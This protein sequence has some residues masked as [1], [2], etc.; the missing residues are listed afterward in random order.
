VPVTAPDDLVPSVARALANVP[1]TADRRTIQAWRF[2][3]CWTFRQTIPFALVKQPQWYIGEPAYI[4]LDALAPGRDANL[5]HICAVM[6][7]RAA[8]HPPPPARSADMAVAEAKA[9]NARI[10]AYRA[11]AA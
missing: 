2:M 5:D 10:A 11:E 3:H 8:L 1:A 6:M 4:G 9:I 7:E